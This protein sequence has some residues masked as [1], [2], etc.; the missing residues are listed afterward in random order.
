LLGLIEEVQRY[1][2]AQRAFFAIETYGQSNLI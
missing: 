2:D 1:G